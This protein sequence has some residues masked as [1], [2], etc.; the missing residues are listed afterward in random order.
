MAYKNSRV[1]KVLTNVSID[2]RPTGFI[3]DKIATPLTVPKRTGFLGSYGDAHLQLIDSRVFD[4]GKVKIIPSF[5][6]NI[7]KT[8]NLITHGIGDYI[9]YEDLREV[10]QPFD[11]E[12]DT[13]AGIKSL[14]TI[15]KEYLG[16]SLYR[17]AANYSSTNT[18]TLTGTARFNHYSTSNPVQKVQEAKNKIWEKSGVEAT[19]LIAEL[20]V[21]ETLRSHTALASV[22]GYTG[23]KAT[24]TIQQLMSTF[25]LQEIIVAK[26]QYVNS[27]GTQ[28]GFW[29]KDMI[30]CN[31]M[32]RAMRHQKTFSYHMEQEGFQENVYRNRIDN[33]PGTQE[34]LGVK[35]YNFNIMEQDAGYLFKNVID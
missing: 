25:G 35:V 4:R 18:E 27:A 23:T 31:R 5:E 21:I 2:Y 14:L 8:Y 32:P 7:S 15:E 9:S 24:M 3:A 30:I 10:E 26:A 13:V 6:Y 34:I 19:T 16:S 1:D 17:T 11:V 33:P 29:G 22:Y 12:E 28:G 20:P